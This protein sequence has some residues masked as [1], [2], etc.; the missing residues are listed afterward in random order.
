MNK[1]YWFYSYFLYK[2]FHTLDSFYILYINERDSL[3]WRRNISRSLI[4]HSKNKKCFCNFVKFWSL[5]YL[6]NLW[7]FF[8]R[9]FFFF[10][11]FFFTIDLR[12]FL[13][14]H[15]ILHVKKQKQKKN[16]YTRDEMF[17]RQHDLGNRAA[18][19]GEGL[20]ELWPGSHRLRMLHY[21]TH[22]AWTSAIR[23][24]DPVPTVTWANTRFNRNHTK[25]YFSLPHMHSAVHTAV[26]FK[27]ITFS[28][29]LR[30]FF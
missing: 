23:D 12:F 3:I 16:L 13:F 15:M 26:S 9:F 14:F 5:F 22:R 29:H 28:L 6:F 17:L 27:N 30:E 25:L 24:L 20:E 11:K 1:L 19:H 4:K 2:W 10:C 7:T 21:D 18:V 8:Y